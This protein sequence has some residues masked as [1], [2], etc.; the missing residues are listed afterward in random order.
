MMSP[1][2]TGLCDE[3]GLS[4][5]RIRDI[6]DSVNLIVAQGWLRKWHYHREM[7][8]RMGRWSEKAERE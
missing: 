8:R 2:A 7:C 5:V 4:A 1:F 3:D 6:A